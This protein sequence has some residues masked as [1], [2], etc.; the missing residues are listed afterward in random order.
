VPGQHFICHCTICKSVYQAPY[1]DATRAQAR[2][3]VVLIPPVLGQRICRECNE[4]VIGFLKIPGLPKLAFIE[5][6]VVPPDKPIPDCRRH[7]HFDTRAGDVPDALP[8]TN[9][10]M[11]AFLAQTPAILNVIAK[12]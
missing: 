10:E 11:A 12:G 7:A 2:H 3:A 4:P 9:L 6:A 1:A 5:V 8:E